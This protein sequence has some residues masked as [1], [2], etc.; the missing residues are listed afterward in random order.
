VL[1]LRELPAFC[2]RKGRV[3]K[4]EA[5]ATRFKSKKKAAERGENI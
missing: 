5:F 4:E 1:W 3:S 2:K